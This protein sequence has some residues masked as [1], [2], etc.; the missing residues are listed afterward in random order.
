MQ[1]AE[2]SCDLVKLGERRGGRLPDRL[3]PLEAI[4]WIATRDVRFVGGIQC[5]LANVTASLRR[6]GAT[7]VDLEGHGYEAVKAGLA[8]AYCRCEQP[9]AKPMAVRLWLELSEADRELGRSGKDANH[10]RRYKL[11]HMRHC[12]CFQNAEQELFAAASLGD[13]IATGIRRGLNEIVCR[14][15][16][17]GQRYDPSSGLVLVSAGWVS[18]TFGTADLKALWPEGWATVARRA[19]RRLGRPGASEVPYQVFK[20]RRLAKVPVL[21]SCLAEFQLCVDEAAHR[22]CS[23]LAAAKTYAMRHAAE[24]KSARMSEL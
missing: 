19:T 1:P 14:T 4:A 18:V 11:A 6:E 16:W 3:T 15:Q 20:E 12:I 8:V 2:A 22:G 17:R 23:G 5:H 7:D 9:L 10:A 13:V 21:S 24:Y